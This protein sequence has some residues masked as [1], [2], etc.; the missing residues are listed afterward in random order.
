MAGLR[1]ERNHPV[2]RCHVDDA[3]LATAGPVGEPTPG[4]PARCVRAALAFV[5]SIHP[6]ELAIGRVECD[7]GATRARGGI[8]HTVHDER[9]GL[10]HV[11]RT[12]AEVVG[13][14]TPRDI[15]F[16]EVRGVDLIER[17]VSRVGEVSAVRGPAAVG[18]QR[19]SG[20]SGSGRRWLGRQTGARSARQRSEDRRSTPR[21][22]RTFTVRGPLQAGPRTRAR[23]PGSRSS[24]AGTPARRRR[25]SPG[26]SAASARRRC[27]PGRRRTSGS[28]SMV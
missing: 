12:W 6:Q 18:R 4:L 19:R 26:E 22:T 3:R 25:S 13:L 2:S 8:E 28:P 24:P 1:I 20:L 10:Q 21:K 14:E 16:A 23:D 15:E 27:R 11:F 9:R 17:R 7:D 5:L